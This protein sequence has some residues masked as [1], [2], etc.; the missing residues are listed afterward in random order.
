[1]KNRKIPSLIA[2][3]LLF[4]GTI[5]GTTLIQRGQSVSTQASAVAQP[6]DVLV[7]NVTDTS[8][9]VT[10][11]TDEPTAGFVQWG[12]G[13]S[14]NTPAHGA[15]GEL[16]TVHSIKV[17]GLKPATQYSFVINSGSERHSDSSAPWS[18]TTG[19]TLPLPESSRVLSG[20]IQADD[21]TPAKQ[22]LV[23]VSAPEMSPLTAVTSSSGTWVI[24]VS[25]AR[26]TENSTYATLD[27]K[28]VSIQ[29][30]G[31][32]GAATA[33]LNGSQLS[34]V[35]TIVLGQAYDFTTQLV[36]ETESEPE[37]SDV[38][39]IT[40]ANVVTLESVENGEVVFTDVPEFFG[41]G[42]AG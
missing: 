36:P 40:S 2:I 41:C 42:P 25:L 13:N 21:T 8:F 39:G 34:V 22:A 23:V 35:P 32:K 29:V 17:M 24:P 33:V 7:S 20:I 11:R 18:V 5:A 30:Y 15:G 6:R 10:W 1:M 3:A 28:L 26:S 12:E 4:L 9:T 27:E 14:T 37:T 16:K 38:Q 31:S 19:P